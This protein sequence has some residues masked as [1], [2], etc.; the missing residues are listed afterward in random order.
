MSLAMNLMTLALNLITI[1]ARGCMEFT[2]LLELTQRFG[3]SASVK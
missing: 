1:V 2:K 3:Y